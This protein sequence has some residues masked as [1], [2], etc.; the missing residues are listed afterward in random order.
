MHHQLL[1][2]DNSNYGSSNSSTSSSAD[3]N[4]NNSDSSS[5]NTYANSISATS[6]NAANNSES[7]NTINTPSSASD[8][9]TTAANESYA[10]NSEAS[11]NLEHNTNTAEFSDNGG[12]DPAIWGKLNVDDWTLND[13]EITGYT[14]ADKIHIIIPNS[15]DLIKAGKLNEGATAKISSKTMSDLVHNTDITKATQTIA[16]SKT[17]NSTIEA[18]GSDWS[19]TFAPDYQV[20][21]NE[22]TDDEHYI[23]RPN[24]ETNIQQID[25]NALDTS[26]VTDMQ[27]MLEDL[28]ISNTDGLQDLN[29]SN[30]TNVSFLFLDD[31]NLRDI[32]ALAKWD[33]TNVED[34]ESMFEATSI[35]D[36]SS[37]GNWRMPNNANIRRMFDYIDL[38]DADGLTNWELRGI[39]DDKP[40]DIWNVMYS[41]QYI[42]V[43]QWRVRWDQGLQ[44]GLSSSFT[45]MNIDP[46][47]TGNSVFV[48]NPQDSSVY[49]NDYYKNL[50]NTITFSNGDTTTIPVIYSID[51]ADKKDVANYIKTNYID[52]VIADE[53][54]KVGDDYIVSIDS[55]TDLTDPI[56]LTNA[57][58]NVD[59]KVTVNIDYLDY[60]TGKAI[61]SQTYTGKVGQK[62]TNNDLMIPDNYI[63]VSSELPDQLTDET[64]KIAITVIKPKEDT[65]FEDAPNANNNSVETVINYVDYETNKPLATDKLY[66]A[67]NTPIDYKKQ[68]NNFEN[69]GYVLV[70][71]DLP[72]TND[73]KTHDIILINPKIQNYDDTQVPTSSDISTPLIQDELPEYTGT[74][75][76]IPLVQDELPEYTGTASGIPLV[77][78][79]LP[80]YTGTASG[81]P[82]IQDDLPE[83][84]GT[85]SGIPLVQDDLPEY[86]GTASGIPLIQDDLPEYTDTASGIPL[87]QDDLPEYTGTASGI[88]LVQDDLPEYTGTASGI[89]L[90]Q[91]D[92]PEYTDTASGIPL[93]QDDLPEY[94]GTASGIPLVQDE[95][96]EY[97]GTASGIP[98]VQD[99]LPEYTGTVSGIPLIQD[100]LPE[101]TGTASGMPLVQ[102]DLPEYTE[103]ASG[104]PLVQDDLPEYTGTAS[105]TPLVQDD[106]PEYTGTASGM[107][108]VQDDLPEYTG[109][110]SSMPLVQDDLPE[111]TGTASGI[112]L[113][114]DDLPEYTGTASGIPLVQDDL[115]E[116]TGTVSTM[117]PTQSNSEH[118]DTA[119]NSPSIQDHLSKPTGTASD[120]S[121]TQDDP[122]KHTGTT[123]YIPTTQDKHAVTENTTG[124]KAEVSVKSNND[125]PISVEHTTKSTHTTNYNFSKNS[126]IYVKQD[127]KT[128]TL[129]QIGTRSSIWLSLM[130]AITILL[131]S[132]GLSFS[133]KQKK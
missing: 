1:A 120:M 72:T 71:K 49:D 46:W 12:Y 83:Y 9:N 38:K 61:A 62:I 56:A 30:V 74:A 81:I 51:A 126:S 13:A 14:G 63:L 67:L 94:T 103:T 8:S 102:D 26:V 54:A 105:G 77:Q 39:N 58:F 45:E 95:L 55:D 129:P 125:L 4:T 80:E 75:S 85:A 92:L 69:Q 111:Y 42:N 5:T 18:T 24:Y 84:T 113:V 59:K 99:D 64:N 22:S 17:D 60:E 109:I 15:A 101:Y 117:P 90:I 116:Y 7:S 35:T 6:S 88:P 82:L 33:M 104:I 78:D 76:G 10:S 115:P 133:R 43:S 11:S 66:G 79:D 87:V 36:V 110:V 32:S 93:V 91:D 86:T 128:N 37:L 28:A 29:M 112:P 16:I 40:I 68:L 19:F 100:D 127:S 132:L 31:K 44:D 21:D 41:T 123:V 27:G 107:P 50:K 96:P 121:S 47:E 98:L 70:S 97:T 73:G 124:A 3:I 48:I 122:S 130:G 34:S 25:L 119:S 114:Q 89:P 65:N 57:K 23:H 53:Q 2:I 131:G 20:I 106:L 108:L 118:T 52:K